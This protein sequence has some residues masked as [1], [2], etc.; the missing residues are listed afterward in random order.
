M[1]SVNHFVEAC[2]SALHESNPPAAIQA[3]MEKAL[4]DPRAVSEAFDNDISRS[5]DME[6]LMLFRSDDLM[7]NRVALDPH[8]K[9]LPHDHCIWGFV[10]IYQGREANTFYR[11]N[12]G[13]LVETGSQTVQAGEVL[14]MDPDRIHSIANPA[15]M[16]TIGIHVYL[17]DLKKQNRHLWN[18][19]TGAKEV[20]DLEHFFAYEKRI[21]AQ[22]T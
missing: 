5:T 9:S 6:A 20:F 12:N 7:I 15:D 11:E 19:F 14:V 13:A 8:W 2:R 4:E 18:P 17:G 16:T 1:F 10:G 21:N 3:N 22:N